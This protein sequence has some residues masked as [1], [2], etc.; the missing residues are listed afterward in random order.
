MC[1]NFFFV[2]DFSGT[3][4]PRILKFGT[5]IGNDKLYCVLKSQPHIAYQS[6]YLSICSSPELKAHGELI[7]Y[8]S[9]RHPSVRPSV[10]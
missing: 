8:Q 5:I 2:K 6:F 9:S 4:V 3:T 7:V 10:H 1:V